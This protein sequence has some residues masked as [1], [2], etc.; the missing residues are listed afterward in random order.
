MFPNLRDVHVA[1][2]VVVPGIAGVKKVTEI[3]LKHW[4]ALQFVDMRVGV[5]FVDVDLAD[6]EQMSALRAHMRDVLPFEHAYNVQVVHQHCWFA[7]NHCVD[8]IYTPAS[9]AA[10]NGKFTIQYF[11]IPE[12]SEHDESSSGS[13]DDD[14][15]EEEEDDESMEEDE[16]ERTEGESMEEYGQQEQASESS[17]TT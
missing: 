1:D 5:L 13:D 9:A 2:C 3:W 14:D 7:V 10:A 11:K 12:A 17:T 8:Y 4:Y 15:M 6:A 16:A